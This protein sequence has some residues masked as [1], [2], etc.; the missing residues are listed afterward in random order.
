MS[1]EEREQFNELLKEVRRLSQEQQ[2][3]YRQRLRLDNA[4]Q[5][6]KEYYVSLTS[7]GAVTTK[8]TFKD[9]ILTTVT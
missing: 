2:L 6:T 3:S 7:G 9:G 1:P 5:G 4:L 8:L